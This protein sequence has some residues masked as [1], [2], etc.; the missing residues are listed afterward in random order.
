MAQERGYQY[1]FAAS[2]PELYDSEGRSRKAAT[3]VAV[4]Q[5]YFGGP[6]HDMRALDVGASTGIID[7]HLAQYFGSMIGV[8][9]DT[10]A[11]EHARTSFERDNLF[12]HRGDALNLQVPDEAVDVVICSHVYE[13]V[14]DARRM[15][16]EIFRVLRPG[17]ICYFAASNRLMWNEP[18]Y[19][20]RLLSA[21]PRPI[22]H[23]YVRLAGKAT[24]YHELHLSYWGLK[25]LVKGFELVDYT[26]KIIA[27]PDQY[28]AS[29]MLPPGS[30]KT[31]VARLMAKH[32]YWLVPGYIWLLRKPGVLTARQ[33]AANDVWR[34]VESSRS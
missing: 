18:H 16:D 22:A 24:H 9:I 11:L 2:S 34:S 12:F 3:M 10:K 1:D 14:P 15:M 31:R 23:W 17:G 27:N 29:Y 4:L 6:L 21:I 7:A 20:L 5:D 25:S 13:H 28:D 8:D 33:S 19:N 30:L 26:V 32:V